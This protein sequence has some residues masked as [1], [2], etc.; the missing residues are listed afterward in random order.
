MAANAQVPTPKLRS[1]EDARRWFVDNGVTATAWAKKY[2][3]KRHIV[4]D[5][6]HGRLKGKY[7]EAHRA[8]IALGLKADPKLKRAA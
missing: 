3:F 5:L 6:L 4:I 2:G 1:P 7:G 8:A